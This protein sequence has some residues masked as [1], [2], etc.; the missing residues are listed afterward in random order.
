MKRGSIRP[1]PKQ[2]KSALIAEA[3][4]ALQAAWLLEEKLEQL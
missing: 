3:D 1:K 2:G 4:E